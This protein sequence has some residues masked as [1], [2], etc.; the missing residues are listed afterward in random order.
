MIRHEW[1]VVPALLLLAGCDG[2]QYKNTNITSSGAGGVDVTNNVVVTND[3][4]TN[5][6]GQLG[7]GNDN[8]ETDNGS[9]TNQGGTQD[10]SKIPP[11]EEEEE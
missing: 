10:N 9:F 4:G 1:L 2:L 8:T 11:P 5:R 3:E 6:I 7:D